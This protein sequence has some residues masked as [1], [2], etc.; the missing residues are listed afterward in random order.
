MLFT[1]KNIGT[2]AISLAM[3]LE[4]VV[5]TLPQHHYSDLLK[6][7]YLYCVPLILKDEVFGYLVLCR[8]VDKIEVDL[9]MLT[10]L[11]AYRLLNELKQKKLNSFPIGDRNHN[12]TKKE[13]EILKHMASGLPEKIIASKE[14]ISINTVKYH[15]K[16]I[17]KKL[18][19]ECTAQAVIKCIKL[20]IMSI[21]DI[22]C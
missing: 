3:K 14:N 22:D 17:F 9:K 1:E 21:N 4:R 20:N 18:E 5:Y 2:N 19:V 7:L 6:D 11:T 12:M 8:L 10:D 16:L 15:K 13:L